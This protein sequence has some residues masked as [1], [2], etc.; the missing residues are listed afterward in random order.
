V[1]LIKI[2]CKHI[3]KCHNETSL[4]NKYANNE[5]VC[6]KAFNLTCMSV[7]VYPVFQRRKWRWGE[8]MASSRSHT[9]DLVEIWTLFLPGTGCLSRTEADFLGQLFL[10]KSSW[11][12]HL[13]QMFLPWAGGVTQVGEHLCSK[14]EALNSNPRT[15]KKKKFLPIWLS[16]WS[17]FSLKV[18][19][20]GPQMPLNPHREE[21]R[22]LQLHVNT[23]DEVEPLA[24]I[25]CLTQAMSSGRTGIKPLLRWQL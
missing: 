16:S 9:C 1:N 5:S 18:I 15:T 25:D 11:G 7:W 14:C 22:W 10:V 19:G 23:P 3:C 2:H 21:L 17:S 24:S 20:G 12:G 13:G 8:T 4:C 6:R